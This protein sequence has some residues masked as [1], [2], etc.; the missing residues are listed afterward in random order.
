MSSP[1]FAQST[2]P[3]DKLIEK[4]P[5][6]QMSESGSVQEKNDAHRRKTRY[7]NSDKKHPNDSVTDRNPNANPNNPAGV[8][9][10]NPLG[11]SR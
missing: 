7:P 4:P 5:I 3:L 6:N 10:S 1:A 11:M 2:L 9:P 8:N